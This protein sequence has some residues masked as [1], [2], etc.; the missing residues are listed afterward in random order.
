MVSTSQT[1]LVALFSLL[2]F[3]AIFTVQQRNTVVGQVRRAASSLS[4]WDRGSVASAPFPESS[5]P[6][7]TA[8]LREMRQQEGVALSR[9]R[10]AF[11][12]KRQ[13]LLANS[14]GPA[15]T[16]ASSLSVSVASAPDSVAVATFAA[17]RDATI[18]AAQSEMTATTRH[19]VPAAAP[20]QS[21]PAAVAA[22]ATPAA[23]AVA[24]V[25]AV[26][27][28]VGDGNA[29]ADGCNRDHSKP[30][31]KEDVLC[32][33]PKGSMAFISLA[34]GAYSEMATNW[35]LLLL[36]LLQRHGHGDRA[37]LMALDEAA[38]DSFVQKRFPVV[39]GHPPG[40][41]PPPLRASAP[42]PP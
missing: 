35:A 15:P 37:F 33:V 25:A 4:G 5:D 8:A 34:N 41:A 17:A 6:S 30:L 11:E 21:L 40:A 36:P 9:V 31:E 23:A 14:A 2:V 10:A 38:I 12:R 26:K 29:A 1:A 18:A 20:P 42:P 7:I 16:A 32:R 28:A 3:S 22:A 13:E 27:A 24:P 19:V 39:R